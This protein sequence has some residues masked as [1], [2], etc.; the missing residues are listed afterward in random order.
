M[1]CLFKCL[2]QFR[3]KGHVMKL[4]RENKTKKVLTS[5]KFCR[6]MK[7]KYYFLFI[8]LVPL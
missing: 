2:S 5:H 6:L 3:K 4:I 1:N 7:S 8:N